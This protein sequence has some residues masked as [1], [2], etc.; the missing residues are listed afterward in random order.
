[1]RSSAGSPLPSTDQSATAPAPKHAHPYRGFLLRAGLGVA[2]VGLLLWHYDAR[3]VFRILA[4]ER[5]AN[6]AA[7]FAIFLAG[8]VMSAYR[9]QLIAAIVKVRGRFIEF[10]AYYFIG[11]FTN[12][13]IP[14]MVGGD[15]ARALYL[16]RRHDRMGES[17]ASVIADRGFGLLALFWLAALAA[18]F[19]NYAPL[20]PSVITPT[21]AVGAISFAGFLASPLIARLIPLMPRPLR[22]AGEF[23]APF[24]HRPAALVPAI[25]LSLILQVSLA[26]CQ[27][28]LAAGLGMTT[29]LSLFLLCVPIANVFASLPL[30]L[31]GLGVRESAYLVLF[32][33]AGMPKNDAIALGLLWFAATMLAG[34][35]GAISFLTT[36]TPRLI[37]DHP[38]KTTTP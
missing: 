26:V 35:T 1:V 9:W 16:G 17:F 2:V 8:Q 20:P 7:A 33:M 22:R 24:L 13:F 3:P 25:V 4:R 18:I 21:I 28:L 11:M 14:G 36:P 30:T 38:V 31:N 23:V 10:L 15:S 19:V 12:L 32:G 5:P 34:M 6:F 29:P 37:R 27:Y